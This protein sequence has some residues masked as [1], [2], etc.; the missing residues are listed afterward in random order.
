MPHRRAGKKIYKKNAEGK[1]E[2]KQ[3]C[4]SIENAKK[5][6]RYLQMLAHRE[7]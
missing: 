3:N 2:V 7:K 6:F 4:T 5:A 1:W